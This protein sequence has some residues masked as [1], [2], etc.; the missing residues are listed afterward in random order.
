[1]IVTRMQWTLIAAISLLTAGAAAAEPDLGDFKKYLTAKP[2]V[3]TPKVTVSKETT[4]VTG[5]LT[6]DGSVD[7]V[8]ALNEMLGKGVTPESNAMVPLTR[9]FGPK[10]IDLTI[11][12]ECFKRLGIEELP[13][14]GDYLVSPYDII[15][16]HA[17]PDPSD[18]EG[19]KQQRLF[20]EMDI[21]MLRPW[22]REEFPVF[23]EWIE[24]NRKPWTQFREAAKRTRYYSPV[25]LKADAAFLD[26][27]MN[28]SLSPERDG[29]RL[30]TARAMRSL[31]EGKVND[32][33]ED[34]LAVHRLARLHAR[35]GYLIRIL[36]GG[37]FEWLALPPTARLLHDAK[38]SVAQ[39]ARYQ[40][41]IAGLPP[42]ASTADV[43]QDS[44]RLFMIGY[45]LEIAAGR[46]ELMPPMVSLLPPFVD[47][48]KARYR[49]AA[50]LIED[51]RADW[52]EVLR[53]INQSHDRSVAAARQPTAKQRHKAF[54][55]NEAE[56]EAAV[57]EL[58]DLD[59]LEK[60]IN[61]SREPGTRLGRAVAYLAFLSNESMFDFGRMDDIAHLRADLANT[62]IA[63]ATF[64]AE[65]GR[66]PARLADLVPNQLAVLPVD[67]FSDSEL[68]YKPSDA[69]YR[70]YS[71]GVNGRDDGGR[72]SLDPGEMA[73]WID[74]KDATKHPD[75]IGVRVGV[76]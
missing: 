57:K 18:L 4:Y 23:H 1:M 33:W 12:A 72:N 47:T 52:N 49:T 39:M 61:E 26:T 2:A 32:A 65:H 5:P 73:K 64:R 37:G 69:G 71:V 28:W 45:A 41:D 19:K 38:P 8:A 59:S 25:V 10:E 67:P 30:L 9:A 16:K 68:V 54:A 17:P 55:A 66:Y 34:L 36:T 24:V 51:P 27:A 56:I 40:N 75:D 43:W 53:L 6:P 42:R 14:Q 7:F 63:L 22:K 50:R 58:G 60:R 31:G 44:E 74:E 15:N 70:L 11:R 76:E 48:A 13:E 62:V 3:R 46:Q 35:G 20:D 29:C 21:V